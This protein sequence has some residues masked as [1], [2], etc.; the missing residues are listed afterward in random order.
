MSFST[1]GLESFRTLLSGIKVRMMQ[2]RNEYEN[3]VHQMYQAE[4]PFGKHRAAT[5]EN[6]QEELMIL[7][8]MVAH[9]VVLESF[10]ILDMYAIYQIR[11]NPRILA[12]HHNMGAYIAA[13]YGKIGSSQSDGEKLYLQKLIDELRLIESQLL[14][15]A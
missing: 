3:V 5:A 12:S 14:V 2:S 7:G 8:E 6:F 4:Q 15:G 9:C 11:G 13:L 1:D 10:K